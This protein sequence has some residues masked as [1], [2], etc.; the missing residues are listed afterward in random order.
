MLHAQVIGKWKTIGDIDKTEKAIVEIY[1]QEGKLFGRVIKLLPT[2][3]HTTCDRCSGDLKGQ[4]IEGMVILMGL[5]KTATGGTNGKVLDPSN[6]NIYKCYIELEGPDKL[7]L[8]GYIGT[9]TL[10]RTQYWYRVK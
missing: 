6:G 5:T 7:K 1:E 9:P 8:R 4:P 3:V 10:G 2:A